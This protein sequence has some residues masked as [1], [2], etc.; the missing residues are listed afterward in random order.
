MTKNKFL[1]NKN[2]YKFDLLLKN[3][4]NNNIDD[5]DDL[6][7]F[8]YHPETYSFFRREHLTEEQLEN[9]NNSINIERWIK[10]GRT[11]EEY[12]LQLLIGWLDED[13]K[14][15]FMKDNW[16][17]EFSLNDQDKERKFLTGN[18]WDKIKGDVDL[19]YK[20][21]INKTYICMDCNAD[22]NGFWEKNG[23]ITLGFDKLDK[24]CKLSEY[25]KTYLCSYDAVNNKLA[26]IKINSNDLLKAEDVDSWYGYSAK[27]L[28]I[29]Y[30]ELFKDVEYCKKHSYFFKEDR[31]L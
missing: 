15:N 26:I 13:W 16:G 31:W 4:Y 21:K 20:N 9:I 19:V 2:K 28:K 18:M 5:I 11:A 3:Q 27:N 8:N 1:G 6:I 17:I 14:I 29:N 12:Y 24:L 23:V 25:Y 30:D 10:K 22:Y 7:Y